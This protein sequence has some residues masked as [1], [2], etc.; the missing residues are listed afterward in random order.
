MSTPNFLAVPSTDTMGPRRVSSVS[1]CSEVMQEGLSEEEEEEEDEVWDDD[2]EEHQLTVDAGL[3]RLSRK[4][5]ALSVG[6]Y[7][8]SGRHGSYVS[9]TTLVGHPKA[10]FT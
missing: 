2:E 10:V 6:S 1:F 3:Q 8:Y 9:T 7:A 5:S 4:S